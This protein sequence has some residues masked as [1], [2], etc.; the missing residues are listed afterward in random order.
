MSVEEAEAYATANKVAARLTDAINSAL[1][2]LP[3]DPF[4]HM[5]RSARSL[6]RL[7]A[8]PRCLAWQASGALLLLPQRRQP[9]CQSR[10]QWWQ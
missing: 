1:A 6:P 4:G 10:R 2:E 5:V 3:A 8:S 7:A 9:L